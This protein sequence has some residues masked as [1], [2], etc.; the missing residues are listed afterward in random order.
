[1]I[2]E[3]YGLCV[4]VCA[5]AYVYI[6]VYLCAVVFAWCI[7]VCTEWLCV[8]NGCVY[9][10]IVWVGS[11]NL[12]VSYFSTIIYFKVSSKLGTELL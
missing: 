12:S 7:V 9:S 8:Q 10:M 5:R 4:S 2:L 6:Y 11:F 3:G 1:M